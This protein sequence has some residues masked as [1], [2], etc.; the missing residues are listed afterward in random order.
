MALFAYTFFLI[1]YTAGYASHLQSKTCSCSSLFYSNLNFYSNLYDQKLPNQPVSNR[2]RLFC[3]I[4]FKGQNLSLSIFAVLQ[5]VQS[6]ELRLPISNYYNFAEM[7]DSLK[8]F[9]TFPKNL[10]VSSPGLVSSPS[11]SST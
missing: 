7:L 10:R 5:I 9:F 8:H 6:N 11:L 4:P 2:M 3:K 1:P